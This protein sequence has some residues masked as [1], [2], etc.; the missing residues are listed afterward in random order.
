MEICTMRAITIDANPDFD[1]CRGV[2]RKTTSDNWYVDVCIKKGEP[3][4]YQNLAFMKKA[5]KCLIDGEWDI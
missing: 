3:T 1:G 5:W 4:S 2:L